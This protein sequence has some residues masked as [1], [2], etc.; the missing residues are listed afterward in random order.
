MRFYRDVT[1]DN[2]YQSSD[3]TYSVDWGLYRQIY[4]TNDGTRTPN[5]TEYAVQTFTAMAFGA[6]YESDFIYDGSASQLFTTGIRMRPRR[7]TAPCSTLIRKPPISAERWSI[8][9]R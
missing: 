6:K 1:L 5:G 7:F 3:P 9:R 4:A 2:S 8:S